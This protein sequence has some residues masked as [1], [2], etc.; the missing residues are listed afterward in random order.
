MFMSGMALAQPTFQDC[1]GAIPVCSDSITIG[2]N[3]NGMGNYGNE[4]ANV[5]NCYAPEQRS[6]WFTW[7]VQQSGLLRFAINPASANQDHDWTLFDLTSGTCSQLSSNSGASSAMVRSNTWGTFGAN[8]PTGV[9]TPNGGTGTCNGPGTGNGPKWCSDLSVTAGERYVLHISNW[10]GTT[11]GFTLDFSQST[12]VIYDNVPPAM[13]SITSSITCTAL[14]SLVVRFSENI[15]CDSTSAGDF[16]L[17]GPGGSHT[18]TSVTSP[19]CAL[20]GDYD[21]EYAVHF[22]PPITQIGDYTLSIIPN[23]GGVQDLC[24]NLDTIDSLEF[25]FNGLVEFDLTATEP[26]CKGL[27]TGTLLASPTAGSAPFSFDWNNSLA[28]DSA[29]TNICAGTYIVT[30]TDD[31]ECETI[32]TIIV[33]EPDLLVATVDT[34]YGVSC[35]GSS[36]CDGGAEVSAIGGTSPYF[37]LWQSGEVL[38]TAQGLCA[39]MNTVIVSDTN[40]CADTTQTNVWVPYTINTVGVGDTTICITN[41]ASIVAVS[42]GGTAPYSYIWT[43][44]ALTG[45]VVSTSSNT[46]VNPETTTE[47]FVVSTDL[48]GCVGDSSKVLITVRPELGLELPTPDTICPYDVSTIRAF[49]TGGDELYSFAWSS[50]EFG[51]SIQVGP[52]ESRWY[53][54]TVSD[55]CGTPPFVD[56]VFQQVGGYSAIRANIKAEDDSLCPGESIYLIAKGV[57]GFGGPDEFKFAWK[58]TNDSNRIQFVEPS[59][60]R[61]FV[62]Q[63]SDL[64]LSAAGADTIIIYVGE[65]KSPHIIV[66]PAEACAE[67]EVQIMI[68]STYA[69][70]RYYWDLGDGNVLSSLH[71]DSVLT[72][73]YNELGCHD[74]SMALVSDFGCT[75]SAYHPCAVKVLQQ[76][77]ANFDHSPDHPNSIHPII[78]FEER[79]VDAVKWYWFLDGKEYADLDTFQY[80]FNEFNNTY[81]VELIAVS[82]DGCHD[83][84]RKSLNY[85]TETTVY[86]PL[87]FT[88]N[89]DGLNDVFMIEGESIQNVDFELLI[90]DRWGKQIF[91]TTNPLNGWDGKSASKYYV[92]AGVYPFSLRYRNQ[93]GELKVVYDQVIVSKSGNKTGLR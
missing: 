5:S 60:T 13:D 24:G 36:S 92:P 78:Q 4:I 35:P 44:S 77:K 66:S 1:L 59:N 57:G 53:T 3:H 17:T 50:G 30:V 80:E 45:S 21:L 31:E 87:S 72:H 64:C 12:A 84:L 42:T 67:A 37:Y 55:F 79:N 68:D 26:L 9:S 33:N 15:I 88:P 23:A 41:Y 16:T 34:T 39:G 29:H 46:I 89:E 22:N 14:D 62:V 43:E 20:G 40:G 38:T 56:S 48:N 6:V 85:T 63:I 25:Y 70:Y 27:C 19:V 52:D 11:Y 86:Y 73:V 2:M 10:T 49:G 81:D 61:E 32:D 76:P 69:G 51:D 8:G 71:S 74:I 58:H 83:T 28:S 75:D 18:V 47:Y 93:S 91:G 90:F 82:D 65:T 7:T 54:V